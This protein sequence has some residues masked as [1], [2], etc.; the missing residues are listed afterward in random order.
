[1]A[2]SDLRPLMVA[3]HGERSHLLTFLFTQWGVM[4]H[5]LFKAYI[6]VDSPL[7]APNTWRRK[8]QQIVYWDIVLEAITA[9]IL[10][11]TKKLLCVLVQDS[12]LLLLC[13]ECCIAYCCYRPRVGNQRSIWIVLNLCYFN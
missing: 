6:F 12:G 3:K 10:S 8:I 1:M 9:T 4:Q 7:Q 2:V 5:L 11:D 13:E